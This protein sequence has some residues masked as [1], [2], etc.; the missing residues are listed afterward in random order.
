[1][2]AAG[3]IRPGDAVALKS[4]PRNAPWR[5]VALFT[6]SRRGDCALISGFAA[7]EECVFRESAQLVV[8]DWPVA[9]LERLGGPDYREPAR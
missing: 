1:M 4:A 6:E 2:S 5:V 7:I 3:D 9:D 8:C